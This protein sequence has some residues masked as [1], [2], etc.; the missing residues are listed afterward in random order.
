MTSILTCHVPRTK[1]GLLSAVQLVG[2]V[3]QNVQQL[4]DVFS[5]WAQGEIDTS[6]EVQ[7][8]LLTLSKETFDYLRAYIDSG[9][10]RK[11]MLDDVE[12]VAG[13]LR[14]RFEDMVVRDDY[15]E[16]DPQELAFR[17]RIVGAV[18]GASRKLNKF[19]EALKNRLM[20]LKKKQRGE[21]DAVAAIEVPDDL[22]GVI[23][24]LW[25]QL[26]RVEETIV[27]YNPQLIR[28]YNAIEEAARKLDKAIQQEAN[29]GI[30]FEE[31]EGK[32]PVNRYYRRGVYGS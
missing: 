16:N 30:L 18:E 9:E 5:Q 29:E 6:A 23:G 20:L 2:E 25:K 3:L 24:E 27:D 15:V 31:R 10:F 1:A 14:E 4:Q 12:E 21:E 17:R 8:G 32:P 13:D 11:F 19:E 26:E 28:F 7:D 22:E